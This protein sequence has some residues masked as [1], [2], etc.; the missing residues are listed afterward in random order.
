MLEVAESAVDPLALADD[1]IESLRVHTRADVQ[2]EVVAPPVVPRVA[3]DAE[4]VRHVLRNLLENAAKYSPGGGTV[5]VR[6]EPQE[7]HLRFA[8]QDEGLGIPRHERAHVFERFTG[9]TSTRSAAS[10][11]P[12][13]ASTSRA[14]P[15]GVPERRPPPAVEG[16]PPVGPNWNGPFHG[17]ACD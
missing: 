7:R 12:G 9:S 16:R 5:T 11:G 8:V 14:S 1:V 10:A 17:G 3:G 15:C 6:L 13:P 2:Y 4:R